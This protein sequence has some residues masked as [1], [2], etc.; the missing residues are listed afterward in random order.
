MVPLMQWRLTARMQRDLDELLRTIGERLGC[1]T[2]RVG[3]FV[4]APSRR[5]DAGRHR[6]SKF[7]LRYGWVWPAR[8]V[9]GGV[10]EAVA[11]R[12]RLSGPGLPQLLP[13][14]HTAGMRNGSG[15]LPSSPGVVD[16]HVEAAGAPA[17]A[18]ESRA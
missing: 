16:Q 8:P 6:L 5:P 2:Y 13:G 17:R 7:L 4:V 12:R 14:G 9:A 18:G 1:P 15:G 3:L 10:Y 11:P